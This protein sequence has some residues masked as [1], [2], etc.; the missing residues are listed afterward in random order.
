MSQ[1]LDPTQLRPGQ[2]GWIPTSAIRPS[3][4]DDGRRV[5]YNT[6]I[7]IDPKANIVDGNHRYYG[8]KDIM[9]EMEVRVVEDP[10]Y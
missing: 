10:G 8:S 1:D 2:E 3:Q 9:D 4:P 5:D 7:Q 6:P